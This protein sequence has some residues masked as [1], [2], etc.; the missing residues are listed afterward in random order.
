MCNPT[1]FKI[2]ILQLKWNTLVCFLTVLL[3]RLHVWSPSG[4]I[5]PI[6]QFLSCLYGFL[7]LYILKPMKPSISLNDFPIK[8]KKCGAYFFWNECTVPHVCH[9]CY[10][11][12]RRERQEQE[13]K[14]S[15][16]W[17]E[18]NGTRFEKRQQREH[19]GGMFSKNTHVL[20]SYTRKRRVWGRRNTWEWVS[21]WGVGVE[22]P[23]KIKHR[24]GEVKTGKSSPGLEQSVLARRH[25]TGV[26]RVKLQGER[27]GETE[28]EKGEE[29]WH[30]DWEI[31]RAIEQE[32][33][34]C[35]QPQEVA[36]ESLQVCVSVC[37][38]GCVCRC[39]RER[40][41]SS[42]LYH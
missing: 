29:Q 23:W 38:C 41:G 7:I 32:V 4:G 21:E 34:T 30:D 22:I 31:N 36:R 33:N 27:K 11:E 5:S 10:C 19:E 15:W 20:R 40:C 16:G 6:W 25:E 42:Q 3:T 26:D 37:V 2:W 14:P 1:F 18:E 12:W 8:M 28:E 39:L 13:K 17:K 35:T 24:R 9:V